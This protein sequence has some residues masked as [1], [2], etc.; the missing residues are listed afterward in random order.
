VPDRSSQLSKRSVDKQ[1][2]GFNPPEMHFFSSYPGWI[3]DIQKSQ[4]TPHSAYQPWWRRDARLSALILNVGECRDPLPLPLHA[5]VLGSKPVGGTFSCFFFLHCIPCSANAQA[6][7]ASRLCI[8]TYSCEAV[9]WR[10]ETPLLGLAR[11]ISWPPG[12]CKDREGMPSDIPQMMILLH[13][14]HVRSG[15]NTHS[16]W[17]PHD[18]EFAIAVNKQQV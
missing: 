18:L 1:G 6:C 8:R 7:N 12:T 10:N 15:I 4:V 3:L 14:L 2:P 9:T 11:L 5:D 13:W 17:R 16:Y